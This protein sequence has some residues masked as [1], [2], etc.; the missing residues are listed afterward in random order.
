MELTDITAHMSCSM[1]NSIEC[2]GNTISLRTIAFTHNWGSED[3][4]EEEGEDGVKS[5]DE[6]LIEKWYRDKKVITILSFNKSV[7]V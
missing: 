4:G 1:S 2:P 6:I 3:G 7:K 5:H